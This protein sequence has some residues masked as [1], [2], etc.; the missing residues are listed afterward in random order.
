L[1]LIVATRC[2]LGGATVHQHRVLA[3]ERTVRDRIPVTTAERTLLDLAE[4]CAARDLGR[5]CD[6]GLRRRV[7]TLGRLHEVVAAHRGGGRRRLGP[8]HEVLG[9]RVAGYDPGANAW[10]QRMDRLW[11]RLGLPAAE[12]QYRI[13]VGRRTFRP[14]RAIVDVKI[15]VEWNGYDPHG[16][17]G[18]VDADSDRAALLATAGWRLLAFTSKSRP[19][20]IGESVRAVVAERRRQLGLA[21]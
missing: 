17:R 8:V 11:D 13:R 2:R 4:S 9:D 1:E 21:S 20:L 3:R 7:L 5:M 6:E 15:A 12:R 18:N 16:Y 14:D 19:E 10:E